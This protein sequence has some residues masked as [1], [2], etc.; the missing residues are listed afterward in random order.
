MAAVNGLDVLTASLG[1]SSAQSA[2][3]DRV[4][5]RMPGDGAD[6][7]DGV[8][9]APPGSDV[10]ARVAWMVARRQAMH[11]VERQRLGLEVFRG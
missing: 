6:V 1:R 3:I 10:A 4:V 7:V 11:R 8:G 5:G 2:A 9:W